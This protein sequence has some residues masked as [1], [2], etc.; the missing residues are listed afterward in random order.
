M[1]FLHRQNTLNSQTTNIELDVRSSKDGIVL[2]HDPLDHKYKYTLLK[3]KLFEFEERKTIIV[4]I[5]ESGIEE[6][7][8][9][10]FKK[11]DLS[12]LFLD[13]QIPDIIKL[14]RKF[15]EEK[16]NI[17]IRVSDVECISNNLLELVNPKYLWVDYTRFS[18]FNQREYFNF[19]NKIKKKF[20]QY[21]LILVSPELYNIDFKVFAYEISENLNKETNIH[22]CTKF[23]EIYKDKINV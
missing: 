14:A 13:S 2:N 19:L 17:I 1:I 3:D 21:E 20:K 6:E 7:I 5:K 10:I 12:Y 18:V 23:P 9:E 8:I 4:N 15:P 11:F 22:V 16:S